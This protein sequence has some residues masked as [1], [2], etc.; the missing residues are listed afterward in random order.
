MGISK[1]GSR[2]IVVDNKSYLWTVG[3]R[4]SE[5]NLRV[6]TVQEYVERPEKPGKPIQICMRGIVTPLSVAM[7]IRLELQHGW[8]SSRH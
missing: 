8:D 1:K 6:L 5:E 3:K 4:R 7:A 2:K